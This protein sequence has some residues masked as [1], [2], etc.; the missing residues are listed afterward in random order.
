MLKI[1][2]ATSVSIFSLAV[3]FASTIAWF[4]MNEAVDGAGAKATIHNYEYFSKIS[5]YQY[6]QNPSPTDDAC[7]FNT[8]PYASMIYN[9]ATRS[10]KTVDGSNHEIDD[11]NLVMDRYDPMSK[12]KP[13]LVIAE[14]TEDVKCSGEGANGIKVQARTAVDGF[15][16][17]KDANHQPKYALG[18]SSCPLI[19]AKVDGI[20]YY[21]LSSVIHFKAKGFTQEEYETWIGNKD[22]YDVSGL[23]DEDS[24]WLGPADYNFAE[25]SV[26]VDSSEF[27][28]VSTVYSSDNSGD[29]T[30]KYIAIVVDYYDF[31]IEYIYSTYL[32]NSMLEGTY[33]YVLNFV[34]DWTWEIG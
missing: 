11:F 15:L 27:H 10:F 7:S 1:I 5:Y 16:G 34:C 6:L 20:D 30:V 3:V 23:T 33:E 31:G 22:R 32:G 24:G 2:A 28:N 19:L 9:S 13:I 29:T 17:Q 21:P 12:H 18:N 14:L 8:T 4:A 26:E 25:A